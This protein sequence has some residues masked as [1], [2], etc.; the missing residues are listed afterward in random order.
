MINKIIRNLK[1]AISAPLRSTK[2]SYRGANNKT[3]KILANGPSLK[4]DFG[5]LIPT[6]EI[7]V[8]NNFFLHEKFYIYKP[9]YYVIVDPM[10]FE[11]K[12]WRGLP[13]E[14]IYK[15]IVNINWD[16]TFFI[17]YK[18]YDYFRSKVNNP[19]VSIKT[20][21]RYPFL[22]S[23][24]PSKIECILYKLGIS[25]PTTQNV[26]I[27]S[28]YAMINM[29]FSKIYLYGTDHSWTSQLLVNHLN[30]VC[31]S[32]SHFYDENECSLQPWLKANGA[33]YRMHEILYDL[34]N[35]FKT[36]HELENYASY[37]SPIGGISIINKT[38][39]SFIDAFVKE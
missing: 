33:P 23:F 13:D 3:V 21:Y 5:S 32:D 15:V 14:N 11:E 12:F 26:L 37:I 9:Q 38:K 18:Y 6:D 25:C 34:S 24:F 30:Q 39:K 22:H 31:I 27:P 35:A 29:G 10:Y 8:L 17:P 16:I 19:H 36:Y 7:L 4:T 1:M 20:L 28:I 2:P